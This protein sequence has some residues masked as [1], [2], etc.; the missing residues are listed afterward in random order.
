MSQSFYIYLFADET[1]SLLSSTDYNDNEIPQVVALPAETSSSTGMQGFFP[2]IFS[3]VRFCREDCSFSLTAG[4][5]AH[6]PPPPPPHTPGDDA[7][8][9]YM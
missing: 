2:R 3:W 8:T 4:V 6:S 1:T 7:C 9:Q 5:A